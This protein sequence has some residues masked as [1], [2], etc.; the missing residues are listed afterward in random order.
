LEVDVPTVD[1][2]TMVYFASHLVAR[3][4]L[5]PS[6][7]LI[8]ILN[9]LGC[10]LVHFNPDAFTALNCFTMLCECWLGIV[11][12]TN[13]FWYIYS[14]ARYDKVIFSWIGLS[15]R[16]S[17]EKEYIDATFKGSDKGATH[18]WFLYD[19]HVPPQWANRHLLPPL[20]K[21]KWGKPEMTPHLA[22]LVKRVTELRA[23][24]L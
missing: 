21:K 18:R 13:L 12:D 15:L 19:M 3:L 6:K 2:S 23:A 1:G 11:P 10:K 7:F 4:G 14:P 9:F 17:H 5:P 20:I 16:H 22:S 24:G 8:A